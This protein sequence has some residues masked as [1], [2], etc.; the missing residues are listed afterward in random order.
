MDYD[1]KI[2]VIGYLLENGIEENRIDSFYWKDYG[3]LEHGWDMG[4]SHKILY[5]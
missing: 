3:L 5:Y 2:D 4:V 1:R